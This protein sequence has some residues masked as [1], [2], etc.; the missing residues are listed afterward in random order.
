MVRAIGAEGRHCSRLRRCSGHRIW[1]ALTSLAGSLR[2]LGGAALWKVFDAGA[3][4]LGADSGAREPIVAPPPPNGAHEL[5]AVVGE[6][7]VVVR[8]VASAASRER[9]ARMAS[10]EVLD[11]GL[12]GAA[13]G[14]EVGWLR[15]LN[16]GR[17]VCAVFGDEATTL[18]NALLTCPPG[19]PVALRVSAA[20]VRCG[21]C[22]GRVVFEPRY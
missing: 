14:Q 3:Y 21:R 6:S 4:I 12:A 1:K 9:R 11:G 2:R 7:G 20:V 18:D 22:G 8:C 17:S 13:R 16:C 10:V 19:A 15:C 5:E